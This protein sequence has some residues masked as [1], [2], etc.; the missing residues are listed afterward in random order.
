MLVALDDGPAPPIKY[1]CA[2]LTKLYQSV[3]VLIRSCDVSHRCRNSNSDE[4]IKPNPYLT[5]TSSGEPLMILPQNM[6]DIIYGRRFVNFLKIIPVMY[7]FMMRI[8]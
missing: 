5:E 3:A 8:M 2:D 1:Q 7:C 4:P 6:C